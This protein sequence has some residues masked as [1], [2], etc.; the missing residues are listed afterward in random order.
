MNLALVSV[1]GL[2]SALSITGCGHQLTPHV[3]VP[4]TLPADDRSILAGEWEYE[5]GGA[6]VLRLDAQGNGTYAY[7]DGQ[8][9]T[10]QF[11][12]GNGLANGTKKKT[13]GKGAS[14][15]TSQVTMPKAM[16]LGGTTGLETIPHHPKK[17]A[18]SI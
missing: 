6:V 4:N 16:G 12:G 5:D 13:T 11:G 17:G 2:A 18:P 10:H 8:F 14:S 7:K 1:G 3:A 9:E 15:F